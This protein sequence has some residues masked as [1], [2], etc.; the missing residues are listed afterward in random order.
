MIM[1]PEYGR[2]RG[3]RY[4]RSKAEHAPF[5]LPSLRP[6]SGEITALVGG[7]YG[8]GWGKERMWSGETTVAVGGNFTL[9]SLTVITS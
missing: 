9:R 6:W 8:R 1:Y 5:C 3:K 2:G 4:P 7:N